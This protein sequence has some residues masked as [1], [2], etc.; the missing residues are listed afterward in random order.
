MNSNTSVV[1]D[2]YFFF[3]FSVSVLFCFKNSLILLLIKDYNSNVE[4]KHTE[5]CLEN[6]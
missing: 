3:F 1:I 4:L 5:S 2:T 6:N